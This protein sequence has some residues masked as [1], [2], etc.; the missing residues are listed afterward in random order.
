MNRVIEHGAAVTLVGVEACSR[1][2]LFLP[3]AGAR[4]AEERDG[5]EKETM[6]AARAMLGTILDSVLV[7]PE[8]FGWDCIPAWRSM[9]KGEGWFDGHVATGLGRHF[10]F[11]SIEAWRRGEGV[12]SGLRELESGKIAWE[13]YE[14]RVRAS[15]G[16][17][18][19][20]VS[21]FT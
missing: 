12:D 9:A 16:V 5:E 14:E 18:E 1:R 3:A 20:M 19:G 6:A 2:E 13:E 8:E 11:E 7:L 17:T 10:R 4:P 21:R 15:A